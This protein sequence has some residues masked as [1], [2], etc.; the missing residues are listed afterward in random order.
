MYSCF[1]NT[2]LCSFRNGTVL[3]CSVVHWSTAMFVRVRGR[4]SLKFLVGMC[5]PN[6]EFYTQ[7]QSKIYDCPYSV[8][9]FSKK[10]LDL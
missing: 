5:G 8:S 1:E 6:L 4:Y 3:A 10:L 7:F 2:Y 9:D